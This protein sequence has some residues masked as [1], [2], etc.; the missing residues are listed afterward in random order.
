MA[1][2]KGDIVKYK[3][4]LGDVEILEEALI[5]KAEGD[6]VYTIDTNGSGMYIFNIK[7]GYCYNDNTTFG[8]KRTLVIQKD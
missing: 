4:K 7:T 6:K 8:S 5:K 3:F 1:F 2:N